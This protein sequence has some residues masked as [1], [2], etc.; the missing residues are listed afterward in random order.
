[1]VYNGEGANVCCAADAYK[2][3]TGMIGRTPSADLYH[4]AVG[5]RYG[6]SS[7]SSS[8]V[9]PSLLSPRE[10]SLH[11]DI[12]EVNEERSAY[13]PECWETACAV[14]SLPP[15]DPRKALVAARA[16]ASTIP[17]FSADVCNIDVS[18]RGDRVSA[19]V[20]DGK[21][22]SDCST[23][24]NKVLSCSNGIIGGAS[25][26][27]IAEGFAGGNNTQDVD[28]TAT[29]KIVHALRTD[30]LWARVL[31]SF[32]RKTLKMQAG[33]VGQQAWIT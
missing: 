17:F 9:P 31:P 29:A 11:Q 20:D 7:T 30:S 26:H 16:A 23:D 33:Q 6:P 32:V 28:T 15:A 12:A 10:T 4:K 8:I 19:R 3:C 1:M 25:S 14:P 24:A 27:V 5:H 13:A 18:A 2:L 21:P 22:L